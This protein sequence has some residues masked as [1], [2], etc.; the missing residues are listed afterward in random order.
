MVSGWTVMA[1]AMAEG[2]LSI[3]SEWRLPSPLRTENKTR[4][5]L[6]SSSNLFRCVYI[7]IYISISLQIY[8]FCFVASYMNIKN[9]FD[10]Q[11]IQSTSIY[12]NCNINI[13]NK[14][15]IKNPEVH[16]H[17]HFQP[18][19]CYV[20]VY[21]YAFYLEIFTCHVLLRNSHLSCSFS[22]R[23]YLALNATRWA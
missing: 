23:W 21:E 2:V 6:T 17:L 5:V 7:Y 19:I 20:F 8:Y 4:S 1:R 18:V 22:T 11:V 3:S 14:V 15:L 16:L 13:W 10:N 12:F 9:S